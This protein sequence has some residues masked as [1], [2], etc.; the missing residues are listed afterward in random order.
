MRDLHRAF[1]RFKARTLNRDWDWWT[2]DSGPERTG[3]STWAIEDAMFTSHDDFSKNWRERITYDP[4]E[5]LGAIESSPRLATVILDEAAE[6]WFN[7]EFQTAT[8][9][10]IAKACTQ[11]GE[12]NLNVIIVTP[13]IGLIDKAGIRRHRTWVDVSAPGFERGYNEF[14][15][16]HFRKFG[17][18]DYPFWNIKMETRFPPLPARVYA[19]YKKF[20]SKRAAERLARYIDQVERDQGRKEDLPQVIIKKIRSSKL[21]VERLQTRR[22]TYDWKLVLYHYKT[23]HDTAKTV[24]AVL[25]NELRSSSPESTSP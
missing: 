16:P 5:F 20:K 8:N 3:K 14:Y 7:L 18:H 21:P 6:A 4:E 19:D 24:A 10:A 12:R 23:S 15:A 1:C 9:R 25:N 17:K 13:S 22:G 2:L 11:V